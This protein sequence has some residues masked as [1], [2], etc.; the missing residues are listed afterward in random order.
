MPEHFN[1]YP[2]ALKSRIIKK[3]TS[4]WDQDPNEEMA[5]RRRNFQRSNEVVGR[6]VPT[7]QVDVGF[8][9]GAHRGEHRHIKAQKTLPFFDARNMR[10][11]LANNYQFWNS[12]FV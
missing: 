7:W 9:I 1:I 4:D 5:D 11:F 2:N 10:P 3:K 6:L 12:D 8:R